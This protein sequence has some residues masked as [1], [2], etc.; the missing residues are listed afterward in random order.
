[1]STMKQLYV[2]SG[3]HS[4]FNL[5]DQGAK[6]RSS[7]LAATIVQGV[8]GGFSGGFFYTGL[9][10]GYGINI[11]NISII[12]VVPYIASLFT[13]FAPY[14]LERFPQRRVILSVTR[15]AYY[16]VNILGI[17]LLP[18]LIHSD[19]GRTWGL[20]CIVFLAN[21]INFLFSPGYS[22]WHMTYITPEVRNPYFTSTTLVS[23]VSS[24]LVLI[25]A[26]IV[27][28]KL[29][30]QAQ[31]DLIITFRYLAF[32]VAMLDVYFLQKPGEPEYKVTSARPSLLDIFRLPL[33]NKKFRRTML[34][35]GLYAAL[36]NLPNSVLNAWLL[37]DVHTGYFYINVINSLYAV[38]IVAT[39][40]FWSR[41]SQKWGT[42]RTLAFAMLAHAPT[43]IAYGFV[44]AAN[45]MWL[46]TTI[47]LIQHALG[48]MVTF[49]VNNLI[50]INLPKED[51]TNYISFYMIVGNLSTFLGM[52]IG[53]WIVAGMGSQTLS[54]FRASISSVPSLELLQG[55]TYLF[56]A[57]FI[58]AIRKS[59]E[60]DQIR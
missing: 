14:I 26:S 43:C 32:A 34:I 54:I 49:S 47:R 50:Y 7:L 9:L 38:G 60:P 57:A 30:G 25:L 44:N 59:V 5:T 46:L 51:Q 22:P 20:I 53:T 24:S 16:T 23:N 6:A 1:M 40:H 21:T 13:L 15:V 31:L 2:R 10:V 11:V 36:A 55:I 29:E 58:L 28:D 17:T 56:Y 45:F 35:Y 12:T 48:M 52:M 27:T 18:Q 41:F 42:F 3:W 19:T 33:S 8:V 4:I 39:S 37:E